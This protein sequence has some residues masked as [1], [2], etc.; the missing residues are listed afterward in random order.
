MKQSDICLEL[1]KWLRWWMKPGKWIS[2]DV[3]M[4]G[5]EKSLRADTN[6]STKLK[7]ICPLQRWDLNAAGGRRSC[8]SLVCVVHRRSGSILCTK[9]FWKGEGHKLLVLT[10][11]VLESWWEATRHEGVEMVFVKSEKVLPTLVPETWNNISN[12]KNI[13]V[14][15]S[16]QN[17]CIKVDEQWKW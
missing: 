14:E 3:T 9:G 4:Y 5:A 1:W 13:Q 17:R 2:L 6:K 7:E 16:Y 12:A 10:P 11:K 15:R 8:G